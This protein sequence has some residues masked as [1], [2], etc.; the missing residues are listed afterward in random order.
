M[1]TETEVSA[2]KK[3]SSEIVKLLTSVCPSLGAL[4]GTTNLVIGDYMLQDNKFTK[5]GK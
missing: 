1:E 5:V 4:I 2:Q 3:F